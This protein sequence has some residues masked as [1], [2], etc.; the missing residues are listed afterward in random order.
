MSAVRAASA[1]MTPREMRPAS[2]GCRADVQIRVTAALPLAAAVAGPASA[3]AAAAT[4]PA[5]A[6]TITGARMLAIIRA[7][8]RWLQERADV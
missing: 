1:L 5:A 2:A 4:H 8:Y 7:P 3:T 6:S